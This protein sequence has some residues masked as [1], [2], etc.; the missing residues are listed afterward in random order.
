MAFISKVA[1]G[2][3]SKAAELIAASTMGLI[4]AVATI[5]AKAAWPAIVGSLPPRELLTLLALSVLW[6]VLLGI[7]VWQQRKPH[8]MHLSL[9]VLWDSKLE[10]HC[11]VCQSPLSNYGIRRK[12]DG[13]YGEWAWDCNKCGKTVFLR[14]ADGKTMSIEV[15]RELLRTVKQPTKTPAKA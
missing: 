6:N 3:R 5:V 2:L 7:V 4:V 11:S 1:E 13:P 8:K 14:G 9:G 12:N 10:A 15:A